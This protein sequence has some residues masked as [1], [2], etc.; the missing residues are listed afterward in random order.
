MSFLFADKPSGVTTHTSHG[1][2][3]QDGFVEYLS[4]RLGSN[5]GSKVGS[6]IDSMTNPE[7]ASTSVSRPLFVAHRLDKETTGAICFAQSKESAEFLRLAFER[8]EVQKR[9]L[10]LTDKSLKETRT[11]SSKNTNSLFVESFIERRGS[12]FT[13]ELPLPNKPANSY[14]EFKKIEEGDRL[15]LW[16]AIP[17]TG[18]SHQI[19]L[20]AQHLGIPILGDSCHGGSPFPSLCLH[21]ELVSFSFEGQHLEFHSPAPRFFFKRSL[22]NDPRLALWLTSI[23]RRERLL[24][25]LSLSPLNPASTIRWIHREGDPLRVEQLGEIISLSWFANAEP[26]PDCR[27][28]IDKLCEEMDWKNW[29]LRHRKDRGAGREEQ[30]FLSV[31]PP[32]KIWQAEENRMQFEFRLDQ[33]LSP[34]LFLDQRRNR[35]W[36]YENAKNK[37]VLNLFSYT[38]GFSVAAAVGKAMSVVSVDLNRRFLE[39][40][41]TNFELNKVDVTKHEFRYMDSRDYLQWAK[42]KGYKFNL[43]V[44]DPPSFSRSEKGV[45][46][47]E[48]DINDLILDLIA[49][50]EAGGHIL[51]S[52]NFES[53]SLDTLLAKIS[54]IL[55]SHATLAPTPQADWDF[56]L[57]GITANMKS[58]LIRIS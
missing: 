40:S 21:S 20:H 48:N 11:D 14:T 33:G 31:P 16:E 7:L 28:S 34:G 10:F 53:W 44:C 56:E 43:V 12:E 15:S 3:G 55:P 6:N 35:Q 51:F 8:R 2:L 47:I 27:N 18:K 9:Y 5:I 45:F 24:R 41:K 50:T 4:S 22:A 17:K 39:W 49:V 38:G 58:V 42:K 26:S 1:P 32:P 13:S 19:R 23:D 29:F 30:T 54:K 57:P 36:V 37:K 25:S 52:V 46:R